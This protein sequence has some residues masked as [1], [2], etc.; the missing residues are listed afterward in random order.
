M[1]DSTSLRDTAGSGTPPP[2][3]PTAAREC[4]EDSCVRML[5]S[6]LSSCSI[7][8]CVHTSHALTIGQ[9]KVYMWAALVRA[10]CTRVE[11][12]PSLSCLPL[13]EWARTS[14]DRDAASVTQQKH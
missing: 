2:P 4:I 1:S 13:P 14:A 7:C 11:A 10:E 5:P 8:S 3:L 12:L 6:P 9:K